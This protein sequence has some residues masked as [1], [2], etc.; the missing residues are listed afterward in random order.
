MKNGFRS[1]RKYAEKDEIGMELYD[2]KA[3]PLE[4]K[5]VARE[6]NYQAVVAKMRNDMLNY[7]N[8]QVIN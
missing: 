4:T 3:D 5:N 7:F 6:K 2:Y 8:S 1:T